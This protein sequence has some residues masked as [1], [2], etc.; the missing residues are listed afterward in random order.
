[1]LMINQVVKLTILKICILLGVIY[2]SVS[3]SCELEL[4]V[5]KLTIYSE[6]WPPYQT[7]NDQG[8]LAG[9]ATKQ[10]KNA[11]QAANI[12]FEIKLMPWARALHFSK[13]NKNTL[14]Y[15]LSRTKQRE[16]K[17]HWI[18]KLGHVKTSLVSLAE[19]SDLKLTN[20]TDLKK[21]TLIL[22]R[23]EAANQ[24]FL[25]LGFDP[26][27][28][29]IY[30]NNSEQAL[31]LLA[32][33]RGDFYPITGSGFMPAVNKSGLSSDLFAL[34]YELKEFEVD[35]YLAAHIQSEKPFID[36]IKRAFACYKHSQS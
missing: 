17:F 15:S 26:Q 25:D 14:I 32:K 29:I 34:I 4:S 21:Y 28:N 12:P 13:L 36:K 8:F 35:L 19:R 5:D 23:H 31:H 2:S 30:V 16:F 11:F 18:H 1:M 3:V 24:Y 7:L 9:L 10:V 20:K 22:K 33:G 6:V 27:L